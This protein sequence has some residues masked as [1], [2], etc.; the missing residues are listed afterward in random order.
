[1]ATSI[2]NSVGTRS[3]RKIIAAE[4]SEDLRDIGCFCFEDGNAAPVLEGSRESYEFRTRGG[5]VIHHP[6]AY[7]K[8][9][10]S[11]MVYH[12]ASWYTVTCGLGWL[13]ARC[14]TKAERRS[15][16]AVRAEIGR[17]SDAAKTKIAARA[18]AKK[19]DSIKSAGL[20]IRLANFKASKAAAR[21]KAAFAARQQEFTNAGFV[22]VEQN[23]SPKFII[24]GPKC[25]GDNRPWSI[26]RHDLPSVSDIMVCWTAAFEAAAVRNAEKLA[27]EQAEYEAACQQY[28]DNIKFSAEGGFSAN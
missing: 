9:G 20:A 17:K 12:S 8:R 7:S 13:A 23:Y 16:A 5:S 24:T 4:V 22:L 11:N 28:P 6:S 18:A 15:L 2:S 25:P 21:A 14:R 3:T 19:I 1:M 27:R 26:Q 10:W